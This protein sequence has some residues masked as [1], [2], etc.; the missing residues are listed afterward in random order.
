MSGIAGL[1]HFADRG[2]DLADALEIMLERIKHRGPDGSSS[3]TAPGVALGHR[4]LMTSSAAARTV[5]LA[6]LRGSAG[7]IAVTADARI[8]NRDELCDLLSLSPQAA[9]LLSDVELLLHA[10]QRWQEDCPQWLIGDFAFAVWDGRRRTFFA[11]RDALG[12][13]PL[14]YHV[15]GGRSLAFASEP[16]GVLAAPDVPRRLNERRIADYL[17]SVLDDK[18]ST[19]FQDVH[20]LPPGHSLF[21]S[22]TALRILPYWSLDAHR[23]V[24]MDSDG[25]YAEAFREI[26]TEAVRTRLKDA[27]PVGAMLSGGLDSSSIVCVARRL[28]G[29]PDVSAGQACAPHALASGRREAQVSDRLHTF[30]LIFDR[31]PQCDERP[32]IRA[33]VDQGGVDSH[34][35]NGDD[36]DPFLD[37]EAMFEHEDEPTFAPNLFLHWGIYR[38]AGQHGVRVLLDGIDG[39]TTVSHGLAYLPELALVGRWA[40]LARELIWVSRR[41]DESPWDV[42]RNRVLQSVAGAKLRSTRR[43]LRRGPA[44]TS[45]LSL[46]HPDFA[47]RIGWT[48]RLASLDAGR[49]APRTEREEHHLRLT[50]GLVPL[51]LEA[52][53]RA[54]HAFSIEP[55]YPFCDRRLV[56]FCLGL[57][58]DQK[59][60]R[61]WTRMVLRRAM[62]A[63]LPAEVQWRPGKTSLSARFC[64]GVSEARRTHV[65]P[66]IVASAEP[67]RDYIDLESLDRWYQRY[68]IEDSEEPAMAI[69]KASTLALWLRQSGLQP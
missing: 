42:L 11:A 61:G 68:L 67:I 66:A 5:D 1:V 27:A 39:D 23:E 56:E 34:F 57:P 51:A 46:L 28:L 64:R 29:G 40:T 37:L 35:V 14:C 24:R 33:V 41:F 58:G 44:K 65:E 13:K 26:F 2:K 69:W 8:D 18:A 20:R 19:F 12:V 38:A 62:E 48:E 63:T 43:R 30:S 7:D 4:R 3:W 21:M 49:R 45:G 60:N 50:R 22:R 31:L 16:K 53:D 52:A 9:A 6:V 55:R 59:L 25:E 32:Y 17:T 15:E 10:Y 54:A 36:L 47:R